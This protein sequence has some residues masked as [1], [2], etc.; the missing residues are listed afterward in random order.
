MPAT[1]SSRP[2]GPAKSDCSSAT[3]AR[4]PTALT[5]SIAST[6]ALRQ[7]GAGRGLPPPRRMA[8]PEAV[9]EV[10]LAHL[11]RGPVY[12]WGQLVGLRAAWRRT[13]IRI[14]AVLPSQVVGG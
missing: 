12:N 2:R 7:L 9:A 11:G 8:S 1:G 3:P 6:A 4:I 5:S 13:R 10:G 14:V